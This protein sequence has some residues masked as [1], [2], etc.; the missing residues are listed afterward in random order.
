M[1]LLTSHI[2]S[3]EGLSRPSSIAA[4]WWVGVWGG[5]GVSEGLSRP[6]SIAAHSRAAVL[7]QRHTPR[8]YLGPP[9]L[10]P[11]SAVRWFIQ[12]MASPRAYLGPPPLRRIRNPLHTRPRRH[13]EGLSRPSSIAARCSLPSRRPAPNSEGLSRPSSIAAESSWMSISETF[14]SEG[15]SRPSSIAATE[16]SKVAEYWRAPRAYLG[17]PPLRL[18]GQC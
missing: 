6:S 14:S 12:W 13:S 11:R 1:L 4:C 9:P 3:S 2:L 18:A 10:R 17:P 7:P 8:A 16:R 5:T 15:L